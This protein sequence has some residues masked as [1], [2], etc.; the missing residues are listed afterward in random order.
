MPRGKKEPA[1]QIIPY[2][3]SVEVEVGRLKRGQVRQVRQVTRAIGLG[4]KMK[5]TIRKTPPLYSHLL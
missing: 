5:A 3:T 1:E 2:A 4:Q